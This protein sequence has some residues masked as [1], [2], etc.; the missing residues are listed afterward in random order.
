M[1]I[2]RDRFVDFAYC[3]ETSYVKMETKNNNIGLV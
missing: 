3:V 1:G 2:S